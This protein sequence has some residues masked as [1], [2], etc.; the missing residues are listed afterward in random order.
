MYSAYGLLGWESQPIWL[1]MV[2]ALLAYLLGNINPSILLGKAVGVDI[3][4]EGSGNPGTTNTLRVLGK[5]AALITLLVDILKGTLAVVLAGLLFGEYMA[6]WA[7][8]A[9]FTG[10]VWPVVFGFR[11]GKGVATA[12]GALAGLAPAIGFG[13]LGIVA[14]VIALS[15]MV[16]LGSILGGVAAP[17]LAYILL[18]AFFWFALYMGCVVVLRHHAN[19]GRLLRGQENKLSFSSKK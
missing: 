12:F 14:L 18:P 2:V 16:S 17:V 1:V 19:I 6:M 3:R 8:A 15:R 11:G 9:V 10:H 4:K 13:C 5:K 7:C